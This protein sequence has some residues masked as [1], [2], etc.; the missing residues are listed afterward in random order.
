LL[1]ENGAGKTTTISMLTGLFPPSSGSALVGGYNI[2]NEI[3]KVHIVMGLCPQFDVLWDDLTCMEHILFYARLKGIQPD[4]EEEHCRQLL[5]EVGLYDV[6]NRNSSQLSGGMKRRLSLAIAMAG[7]SRII[8][9]DEPTTGLDPASRRRIWEI[10]SVA[11]QNRAILLTTHG[12]DEAE[13]LCDEIGILAHGKLRCFGSPQHL[14]S[15]YGE[16]YQLTLAFEPK[17]L[18]MVRSFVEELIPLA[19]VNSKFRGTLEYRIARGKVTI[20]DLFSMMERDGYNHGITDWS[21]SQL[22][23]EAVFQK[24]VSSCK[25]EGKRS[26]VPEGLE[27]LLDDSENK[28]KL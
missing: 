1:G 4:E 24:I 21:I 3:D 5:R 10:I 8:F 9:L 14:S 22:G 7:D 11:K 12:M 16:G 26:L 27:Q 20:S 18:E 6:R 15:S 23:L 25:D 28:N 13:T 19:K 17:N 2:V